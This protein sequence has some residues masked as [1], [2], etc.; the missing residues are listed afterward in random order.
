MANFT[1][2]TQIHCTIVWFL[3]IVFFLSHLIRIH[4]DR[5][6]SQRR[7]SG[8]SST[9]GQQCL[10]TL[11][12]IDCLG[13]GIIYAKLEKQVSLN[14]SLFLFGRRRNMRELA[15]VMR[16]PSGI[17]NGKGSNGHQKPNLESLG[18]CRFPFIEAPV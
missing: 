17:Q 13:Q 16:Q 2:P 10:W 1:P 7:S 15:H 9:L 11:D 12:T 14:K 6:L 18:H 3:C 8:Y 5:N 4:W